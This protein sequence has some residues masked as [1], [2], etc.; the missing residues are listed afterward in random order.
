[1]A[2]DIAA[3]L[4]IASVSGGKDS[5]AVSLFLTEL[6]IEHERV[7]ADTGWEAQETYDYIRGPLTD[8]LGPITEIKPLLQME[9]L[10]RKKGMFPSRVR[11]FCTE[12]LKVKPLFEYFFLRMKETAKPLVNTVGI[13]AQESAARAAM[14]EWDG[15]TDKRG[16]FDI[17]R[18]I[19]AWTM[20]DVIAIHHRHGLRPN[21]LYMAG[22]SRVG[23]WPCI[24]SRKAE[25]KFIADHDPS[26]IDL[27]AALESEIT[28]AA[29]A[30]AAAKGETNQRPRSFFAGVGPKEHDNGM[31]VM[32]IADVV[33]WARTARGGRQTMLF[34]TTDPDEGCVRWGMCESSPEEA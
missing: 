33:E 7:F 19:I 34:D 16:T 31:G 23:C 1:M 14:P 9:D 15:Y 25:I 26:R 30:R 4:V 3:K 18:P 8:A 10:I 21:P 12:E 11:R 29:H 5:T 32:P 22:A 13:R 20:E 17:W 27:I 24:H 6:G 28:L 2:D